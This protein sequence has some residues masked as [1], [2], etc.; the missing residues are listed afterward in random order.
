MA[1]YKQQPL[2][3]KVLDEMLRQGQDVNLTTVSGETPL[4][5]ACLEGNAFTTEYLL[6]HKADVAVTNKYGENPFHYACRRGVEKTVSLL[7]EA[8]AEPNA[9]VSF[10][11]SCL[12][13]DSFSISNIRE[14]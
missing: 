9:A 13:Y 3:L 14:D 7:L 1:D 4:H 6:K 8:G 2:Q 12:L 5:H 10:L 11:L